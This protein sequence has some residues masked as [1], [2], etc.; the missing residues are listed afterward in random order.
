M[1]KHS[2]E[3]QYD[4]IENL[5]GG[6]GTLQVK[7]LFEKSELKGNCRLFAKFIIP[8]G[9]S[10]GN[11]GHLEEEELYY[12]IKGQGRVDDNG[13]PREVGPGDVTITASGCSHAIENI[14]NDDLELIA[15]VLMY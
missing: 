3:I 9:C 4:C 13:E 1:V 15:V 8:K 11:H 6:K 14:G 12:I 2:S 5:R 7:Q 10:I